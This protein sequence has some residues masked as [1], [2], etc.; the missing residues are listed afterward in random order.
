MGP[1]LLFSRAEEA[2]RIPH[3]ALSTGFRFA[4]AATPAAAATAAAAEH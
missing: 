3:G 4:P 2:S 1:G